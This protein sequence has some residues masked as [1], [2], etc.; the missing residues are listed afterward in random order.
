VLAVELPLALGEVVIGAH[1]D[2]GDVGRVHDALKCVS[3][4]ES[5]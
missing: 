2:P 3:G 1:L 4:K 5:A